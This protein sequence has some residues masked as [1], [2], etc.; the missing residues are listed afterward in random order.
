MTQNVCVE[1]YANRSMN[2]SSKLYVA[3]ILPV[4]IHDCIKSMSDGDDSAICK[5]GPDGRLD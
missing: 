2:I 1:F 3:D 5:L 4:I